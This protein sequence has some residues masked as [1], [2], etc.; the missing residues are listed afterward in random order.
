MEM[1]LDAS[2]TLFNATSG[3]ITVPGDRPGTLV[4]AH[5]K[6]VPESLEKVEYDLD[7]SLFGYVFATGEPFLTAELAQ[8]PRVHRQALEA[9]RQVKQ[10]S[11]GAIYAPLQ[12]D[13]QIIGIVSVIS[14]T[15]HNFTEED[16]RL[17]SAMAEIAGSNLQ[18]AGLMET[19]EQ[20]VD[21]RTREL[22]EANERLR[23][24]DQLKSKFVSDISHELRTPITNLNLYLDLLEQGR[25]E[26]RDHY[27]TV[28]RKQANRLSQLIEGILSLSQLQ[29]ER[30]AL[31]LAPVDFNELVAQVIAAYTVEVEAA[32]LAL[33][34]APDPQL[35]LVEGQHEQLVQ[36]VVNLLRNA[37]NYTPAGRIEVETTLQRKTNEVC[38]R[39]ADSG[40]GIGPED[41]PHLFARFYRGRYASQSNIPGTG[42]GLSI[43]KEVVN[44]HRGHI[45]VDSEVGKGTAFKVLLPLA[46][47]GEW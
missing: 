47:D 5:E 40:V 39:V 32:G 24:L 19:L 15:P 42:L 38:L 31:S 10:E 35:P 20:R 44:L 34:F 30:D 3:A 12:A 22:A 9:W 18:R 2:L 45:T 23:E 27:W 6:G 16:L 4:I 13:D 29:I 41:L 46:S 26:R 7:N 33:I 36:V 14:R 25:P 1:L 21:A 43:V 11:H 8:E 17:L 37:I 28:L